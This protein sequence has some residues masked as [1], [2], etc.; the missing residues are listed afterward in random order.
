MRINEA[1]S[2]SCR[3]QV[4]TDLKARGVEDI[5]IACTDNLTGF[6][7]AIA[8]AFPKT[9]MQLCVLHQIRN[10]CIC[11]MERQNGV[12]SRSKIGLWCSTVRLLKMP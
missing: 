10:S 12:C 11:G 2:A 5:L 6:T 1:E 9:I 8:G 7:Q 4:L 3:L